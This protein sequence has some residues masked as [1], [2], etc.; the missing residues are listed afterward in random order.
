[1]LTAATWSACHGNESHHGLAKDLATCF[2]HVSSLPGN[3]FPTLRSHFPAHP[4]SF[5]SFNPP[6]NQT[7]AQRSGIPSMSTFSPARR[8]RDSSCRANI[9]AIPAKRRSR[10]M[11]PIIDESRRKLRGIQCRR[12]KRWFREI[13]HYECLRQCSDTGDCPSIEEIAQALM[14]LGM[15]RE[16]FV[17]IPEANRAKWDHL[18]ARWC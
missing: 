7:A 1:M 15:D 8:N 17:A 3:D 18:H 5:K 9:A 14:I 10:P 6:R 2:L 12:L 16:M 13:E 11:T 4:A